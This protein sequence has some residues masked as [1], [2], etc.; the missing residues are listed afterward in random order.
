MMTV[1]QGT[2]GTADS[3]GGIGCGRVRLVQ[4]GGWR[5]TSQ[6]EAADWL[7]PGD[8]S[9]TLET[10]D[11]GRADTWVGRYELALE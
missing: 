11:R 1:F 2:D 7:R 6:Y 9:T 10:T 3:I 8:F 5:T 4:R